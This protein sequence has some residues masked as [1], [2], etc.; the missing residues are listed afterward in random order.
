[1]KPSARTHALRPRLKKRKRENNADIFHIDIVT[2][3]STMKIDKRAWREE[4]AVLL[5]DDEMI[6]W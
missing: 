2:M 4:S 6:K 1:M 3:M 5:G